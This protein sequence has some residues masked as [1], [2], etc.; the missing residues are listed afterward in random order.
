[1]VSCYNPLHFFVQ[2]LQ[3][4]CNSYLGLSLNLPIQKIFLNSPI[5]LETIPTKI[6]LF[7]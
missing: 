5:I 1:M 6:N 4:T 7:N 3:A 2:V